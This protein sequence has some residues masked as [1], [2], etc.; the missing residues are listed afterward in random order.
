MPPLFA[1]QF[2]T[3]ENL[4]CCIGKCACYLSSPNVLISMKN[5]LILINIF[6]QY[7]AFDRVINDGEN[8]LAIISATI[9]DD[10]GRY[11]QVA[12]VSA[13][14]SISIFALLTARKLSFCGKVM[15]SV[16]PVCMSTRKGRMG[17]P[18]PSTWTPEIPFPCLPLP[19]NRSN[20]FTWGPQPTG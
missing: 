16:M 5:N 11:Q 2:Y 8:Y 1:Q 3:G 19:R 17:L 10:V 15:F 9:D 18:C 12:L 6:Q 7:E 4:F 14:V 13:P 20:L